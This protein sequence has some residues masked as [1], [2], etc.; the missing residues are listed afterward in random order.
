MA[1][2]IRTEEADY[3]APADLVVD[4]GSAAGEFGTLVNHLGTDGAHFGIFVVDTGGP[5]RAMV[6]LVTSAW[7]HQTRDGTRLDDAAGR[8]LPLGQRQAPWAASYAPWLVRAPPPEPELT[9]ELEPLDREGG[10]EGLRA[11]CFTTRAERPIARVELRLRDGEGAVVA[12]RVVNVP[13]GERSFEL[14][15]PR[16]MTYYRPEVKIGVL[17]RRA[18]DM[19]DTL[20]IYFG[21]AAASGDL[22]ADE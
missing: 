18:G 9:I 20:H 22:P 15:T 7:S 4:V 6:G 1:G 12:R 13:A 5:P 10:D 8:E 2:S 3:L 17:E 21:S 11:W 19:V 16:A 14:P